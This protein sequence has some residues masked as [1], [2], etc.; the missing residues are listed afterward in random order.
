MD[1]SRFE[2]SIKEKIF[3]HI[4]FDDILNLMNTWR[5]FNKIISKSSLCMAKITL[6][7]RRVPDDA[8]ILDFEPVCNSNR[9]Y[10]HILVDLPSIS[11]EVIYMIMKHAYNIKSL[12]FEHCRLSSFDLHSALLFAVNSECLNFHHCRYSNNM[13]SDHNNPVLMPCMKKLV[14]NGKLWIVNGLNVEHLNVN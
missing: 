10:Q 2:H 3:S 6:V 5:T 12:T 1:F 14:I 8:R 7:F 4:N 11:Q 9:H 13:K